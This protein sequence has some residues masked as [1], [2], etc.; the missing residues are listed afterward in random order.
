MFMLFVNNI[1]KKFGKTKAN[2][3]INFSVKRGE[4]FGLLGPNGSGKTTLISQLMGFLKPDNGEIIVSDKN[5]IKN[6]TSGR[7]LCSLQPQDNISLSGLTPRQAIELAGKFRKGSH[8]TIKRRT[9]KLLESL[10]L[11]KWAD[12]PSENL[13]GGIRRLTTFCMAAVVPGKLVILDEP[14][15][16]VDPIRRKLLWEQ[17]RLLASNGT[18]IL[19]IT[20]NVLEAEKSVDRLAII[21]NGKIIGLGTPVQLKEDFK[22]RLRLEITKSLKDKSI[23]LPNYAT[24]VQHTAQKITLSIPKSYSKQIIDWVNHLQEEKIIDEFSL[25]PAT[26]EDAYLKIIKQK[27]TNLSG[28]GQYVF[29]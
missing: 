22:E 24:L 16:D 11:E 9:A 15:N 27:E 25:S 10:Q 12:Q 26:L 29:H 7:K 6:P 18:T 17:V 20:H 1:S 5:V 3:H 13:S 14:T 19:L 28:G 23:N 4:V 8:L 21:H 2:D